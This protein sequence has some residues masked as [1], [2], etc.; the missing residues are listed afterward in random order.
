[1]DVRAVTWSYDGSLAIL[2]DTP[3]TRLVTLNFGAGV[4]ASTRYVGA[5]AKAGPVVVKRPLPYIHQ[6]KDLAENGD[7]NWACGPTSVAMSLA[8]YGKIEPWRDMVAGERI[9]ASSA[10]TSTLPAGTPGTPLP[11]PTY[12][13]TPTPARPVT[14]AD[15]APYVTN[16]YTAYGHTYDSVARDPR[17]NL[18]AG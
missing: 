9:S 17:G 8:Y 2:A 10:S 13:L 11:T 18:L 7:G 12:T 5:A 1:Q 14:G 15:F 3:T 16:K 6:V 4:V